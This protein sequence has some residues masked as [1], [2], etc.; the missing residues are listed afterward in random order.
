VTQS[1]PSPRQADARPSSTHRRSSS[2]RAP[3]ATVATDDTRPH[4]LR[5]SLILNVAGQF[6][7]LLIGFVPSILVARWLGPTD[8]GLYAVVGTASGV[9]LVLA[10]AG[11]PMA[12]WYLAS[13]KNPRT[14]QLF[15]NSLV[16]SAAIAVVLVPTT[17]ALAPQLGSWL[18]HGY[19]GVAWVIAAVMVLVTFLDW[20]SHNQLL[21]GHRFG[22]FNALV[23]GQKIVFLLGVVVFLRWVNLGVSGVLLAT[24]A[25]S[26]L[27]ICGSLPFLFSAGRPRFEL[28][29]LRRMLNYG[30]RTQVG[31]LFQ[32]FN[33]RFDVL[34]LQIFQPLSAV[35]YYVVAEILA[36]LVLVFTRGFQSSVLSFVT[37]DSADRARQAETT[38]F[39][40]RQHALLAIA[41]TIANAVF[42]PL[43][44]FVAYGPAYHNAL[45]PFFIILPGIC[46]LGTG[47][48]IANDLNARGRPGLASTLSGAAV[49]IT[50]ALDL[51][52]I[53]TLGVPGAAIGSLVAYTLF[54]IASVWAECR[55]SG[56]P[57][58]E[59]VPRRGDIAPYVLA[60]ERVRRRLIRKAGRPTLS[61]R[62]R[63]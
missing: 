21:G 63:W 29:L 18:A 26:L 44:I 38:A 53:P 51:I 30:W 13:S 46:F 52:L 59:F 56:I 61:L 3:R 43:L 31:G 40:I 42:S 32:Y 9:A 2:D 58:G 45:L 54:G 22:L 17:W 5:R 60:I 41:A 47:L 11:V 48:L 57:V 20:T 34:I 10:N 37:R 55:I 8:R 15:G 49:C 4:K 16:Y 6:A 36:E 27:V 14:A 19:G 25:S 24:I 28:P 62:D 35:G 39:S 1:S 7:T 12:V 23:V 50:I 33:S